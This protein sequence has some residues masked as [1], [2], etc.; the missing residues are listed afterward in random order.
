[1]E[2]YSIFT[3][4]RPVLKQAGE[5]VALTKPRVIMLI[6][7]CAF[8]GMLLA[9]AERLTLGRVLAATIDNLDGQAHFDFQPITLGRVTTLADADGGADTIRR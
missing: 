5:Y 1:M 6:V 4:A 3:F 8:I 9:P 2:T 7:F